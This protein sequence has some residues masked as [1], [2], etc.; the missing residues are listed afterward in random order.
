MYQYNT[1]QY[2]N[3]AQHKIKECAFQTQYSIFYDNN[4][5]PYQ[6]YLQQNP[7]EFKKK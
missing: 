5:V 2:I 7:E 1:I 4:I 3:E 6:H